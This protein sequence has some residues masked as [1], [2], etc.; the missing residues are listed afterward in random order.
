MQEE[1]IQGPP[2][3]LGQAVLFGTQDSVDVLELRKYK[4]DSNSVENNSSFE[5]AA[6][7]HNLYGEEKSAAISILE[8]FLTELSRS[9]LVFTLSPPPSAPAL[10]ISTLLV[11]A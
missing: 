11:L 9:Y 2:Y 4:N 8:L 5:F 1:R 10:T 6:L 7:V 3:I